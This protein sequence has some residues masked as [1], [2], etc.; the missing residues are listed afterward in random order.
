MP[1]N[2]VSQLFD[3]HVVT[4]EADPRELGRRC[5]VF[6]E[7]RAAVANAVE[8]RQLEY[9]ATRHLAHE[10]FRTLGLPVVPLLNR[11][12]RSPIWPPQVIGTLTHTAG[13]CGVAVALP[14]NNCVSLG[15]DAERAYDMNV[16]VARRVLTAAE[17]ERL[18]VLALPEFQAAATLSFSA[19]EAVYKCLWP[20]VQRYVAF[21]E[22]EIDADLHAEAGEFGIRLVSPALQHGVPEQGAPQYGT[23]PR[24]YT[25]HGRFTRSENL[26]VT[27]V[28]M[29]V[30]SDLAEP[31]RDALGVTP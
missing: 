28:T 6:D 11:K 13:W 16:E 18:Q 20:F 25:L 22:V 7:E 9:Y 30:E 10:A 23:L 5:W 4:S 27:G 3:A 19:K 21:E 26:W 15:L 14:Q 24:G 17:F 1:T 31:R 12:D 2:L 29:R 8:K